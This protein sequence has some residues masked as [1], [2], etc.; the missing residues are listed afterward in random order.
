[1]GNVKQYPILQNRNV[2]SITDKYNNSYPHYGVFQTR[3]IQAS[4]VPVLG[5]VSRVQGVA[6]RRKDERHL[7]GVDGGEVVAGAEGARAVAAAVQAV[8]GVDLGGAVV[9][10]G[11]PRQLHA[12]AE[13]AAVGRGRA[14]AQVL[15]ADR[16]QVG[17]GLGPPA[18]LCVRGGCCL[19]K[20]IHSVVS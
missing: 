19:T 10:G 5:R 3:E 9:G 13:D 4:T 11:P 14:G 12:L 17:A 18:Q 6:R 1:V 2:C 7:D 15:L 16:R 20:V 8:A